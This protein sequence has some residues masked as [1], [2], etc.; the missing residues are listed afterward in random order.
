VHF[1][2]SAFALKVYLAYGKHHNRRVKDFLD[3]APAIGKERSL[4]SLCSHF[5]GLLPSIKV[6]LAFALLSLLFLSSNMSTP[7]TTPATA[8]AATTTSATVPAVAKIRWVSNP[9][10]GD[11]NPGTTE[12]AKRF[13][14][15]TTPL[16]E[17]KRLSI[18]VEN[19]VKVISH[20]KHEAQLN[21]WQDSVTIN[22]GTSTAPIFKNVFDHHRDITLDQLKDN[23]WRSFGD[24]P[25]V[26]RIKT[27]PL[28]ARVLDPNTTPAH[29]AIFYSR[30]ML[31]LIGQVLL[32]HIDTHSLDTLSLQ[33]EHY[34]W[35]HVDAAGRI[36]KKHD[37]LTML[38]LILDELRPSTNVGVSKE[39][40]L[41][42][43]A[44]MSTYKENV[45]AL[46]D[47]MELAFQ[48][49]KKQEPGYEWD[50]RHIYDALTSGRNQTFKD[51]IQRRKD[52]WEVGNGITATALIREARMKYANSTAAET[53]TEQRDT[54]LAALNTRI[55]ALEGTRSTSEKS[56]SNRATGGSS[57][58]TAAK[59]SSNRTTSS[60]EEW[61]K[62][63]VGD[64]IEKDDRVWHWCKD[65]VMDGVY[66][67]LY[68][69]HP[70]SGHAEWQ[71][72][73]DRKKAERAAQWAAKNPGKSTTPAPSAAA[74]P[75]STAE[76]KKLA[77]SDSLRA[78]LVTDHAMSPEAVDALM[79]EHSLN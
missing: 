18:K 56:T 78:A 51:F 17:D 8:A 47:A 52:D 41:I 77:L 5:I 60:V 16:A 45:K 79:A 73:K 39:K 48:T 2:S 40:H 57:S 53:Q 46:L 61:R 70:P 37:G 42:E 67:G 50:L 7:T 12:G 21:A 15:A 66:N 14:A 62:V 64:T 76:A 75:P 69:L 38:K 29:E 36:T 72:N 49:I 22:V 63:K 20:L 13:K 43:T 74:A 11:I 30:V 1:R 33:E 65:H 32:G 55:K 19:A 59:S 34:Q 54:M 3:F 27:D 28:N 35:M 31:E 9:N 26:A 71:A 4:S 68:V 23:A 44:R 10:Q 25:T 24:D 6:R 58:N